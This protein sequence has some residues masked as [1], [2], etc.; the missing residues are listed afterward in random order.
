MDIPSGGKLDSFDPWIIRR[1]LTLAKAEEELSQSGID[2]EIED[3]DPEEGAKSMT[4]G[5]GVKL[6]FSG[7]D[8][9]LSSV[10]YTFDERRRVK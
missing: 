8:L 10:S 2:F 7:K 9:L 5:V 3:Y 1:S 6:T 4:G